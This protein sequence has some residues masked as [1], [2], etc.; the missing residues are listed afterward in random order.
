[1]GVPKNDK[2]AV[3]WY[4]KAA[5]QGLAEAQFVLGTMYADGIGVPENDKTA[6]KWYTKAAEQRI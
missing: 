6:V 1:M 5:E 2:A 3:K 4:T